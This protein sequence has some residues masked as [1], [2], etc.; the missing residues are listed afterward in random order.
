M[1]RKMTYLSLFV[2]VGALVVGVALTTRRE[3]CGP[4]I[5]IRCRIIVARPMLSS[6]FNIFA[7]AR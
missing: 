2:F 5:T 7:I 3:L 4:T 1:L 6:P